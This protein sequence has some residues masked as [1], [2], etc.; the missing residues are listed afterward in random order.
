[1]IAPLD[2]CEGER[3]KADALATLEANREPLVTAGRRALLRTLLTRDAATADD[4]RQ[5]VKTPPGVDPKAFGAV[6]VGLARAGI[7]R[8]RGFVQ[9]AR[10]LAHARPVS[11]W[12]LADRGKA[13]RWLLEHP[14]PL[15]QPPAA[16][17]NPSP[18]NDAGAP[19]AT[20]TP[21]ESKGTPNDD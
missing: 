14:E 7:I 5:L 17:L 21:A 1:M 9:T 8:R 2:R 11:E 12:T 13:E 3:R 10:P 4:V 20:G 16:H 19:A 15:P 18:T 6:P